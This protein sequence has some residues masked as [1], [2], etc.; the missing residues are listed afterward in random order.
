[1]AT[2]VDS[3]ST[4][5]ISLQ[6]T[7]PTGSIVT[8]YVAEWMAENQQRKTDV[9]GNQLTITGLSAG[10]QY[11]VNIFSK[12]SAGDRSATSSSVIVTTC[13]YIRCTSSW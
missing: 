12:N 9:T 6:W 7:P 2:T 10:Y 13:K 11:E 1:M 8:G 5:S 3:K 4:T